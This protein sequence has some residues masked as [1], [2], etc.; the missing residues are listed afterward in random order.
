MIKN[1]KKDWNQW[2]KN[3]KK[4]EEANSKKHRGKETPVAF[5][6]D[7]VFLLIHSAR[8]LLNPSLHIELND[9]R[10]TVCYDCYDGLLRSNFIFSGVFYQNFAFTA[11]CDGQSGCRWYRT[12]ARA[13]CID[14]NEVFLADIDEFKTFFDDSILFYCT[15]IER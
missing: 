5:V 12:T 14:N 6:S 11:R 13:F 8:D 2:P 4:M 3:T 7:T 15:Q 10:Y 1:L 9:A